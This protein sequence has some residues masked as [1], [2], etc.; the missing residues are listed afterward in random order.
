MFIKLIK[1]LIKWPLVTISIVGLTYSYHDKLERIVNGIRFYGI[2]V[3]DSFIDKNKALRL[4]IYYNF[5]EEQNLETYLSVNDHQ[6]P[7]YKRK[8]KIIVGTAEYNFNGFT[9]REKTYLC[10]VKVSKN[11][12]KRMSNKQSKNANFFSELYDLVAD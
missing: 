8:N 11:L 12:E 7:V 3:E 6:L 10:S 9:E 1:A 4:R 5:N 2:K